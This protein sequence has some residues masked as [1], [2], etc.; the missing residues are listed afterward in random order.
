M[1]RRSVAA[2]RRR[3]RCASAATSPALVKEAVGSVPDLLFGAADARQDHRLAERHR[4]ERGD[5][6]GF[7]D[8]RGE[9]HHVAA[10]DVR[11]HVVAMPGNDG[12]A[13]QL[14]FGDLAL[15]LAAPRTVA[16]D[17]HLGVHTGIAQAAQCLQQVAVSFLGAQRRTDADRRSR[18]AAKPNS[19][20]VAALCCAVERSVK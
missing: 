20:R 8:V 11:P 7:D 14:Q 6:E 18:W 15:D 5:G 9:R 19:A 3:S 16:D 4:L 1:L 2:V 13:G 10:R 12:M 17:Q